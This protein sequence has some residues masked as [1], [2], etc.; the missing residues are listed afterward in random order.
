MKQR[1]L[2]FLPLVFLAMPLLGQEISWDDFNQERLR[3]NRV[4]MQV[5]GGWAMANIAVSGIS[6]WQSTGETKAF[7]QM[8]LGWNAVNLTLAGFGYFNAINAET[9]LGDIES[10]RAHESILRIFLFNAGLDVGYIMGGAFL[11]ERSKNVSKNSEMLAGFGKSIAARM[12]KYRNAI[13][14]DDSRSRFSQLTTLKR[15]IDFSFP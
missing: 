1:I 12:G 8:N 10:I 3:I 14:L 7:H 5:L 6:V 15:C 4:G 11:L 9:S 2:L 13:R